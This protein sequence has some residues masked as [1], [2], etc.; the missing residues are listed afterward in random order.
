[1]DNVSDLTPEAR[2]AGQNYRTPWS[3]NLDDEELTRPGGM[4]LA[5]L[6]RHANES[7]HQMAEMARELGVTYGY[8]NQLR[9][10]TRHI[11]QISDDFANAC[12]LYLG[13]PRLTVLMLAGRISPED[14]YESKEL[15]IESIPRAMR[16]IC[17]DPDWG[18]LVSADIRNGSYATHFLIVKLYEAATQKSLIPGSIKPDTL[19]SDIEKLRIIQAQRREALT[20]YKARKSTND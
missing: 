2:L 14:I 13:I 6:I 18:H 5:A 15:V 20:E 19:A 12:A 8:I 17:E 10:G 11:N 3:G 16:Y 9:N 4:L 1:M 7:G